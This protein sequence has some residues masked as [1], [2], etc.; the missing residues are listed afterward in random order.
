MYLTQPS[1]FALLASDRSDFWTTDQ[2]HILPQPIWD[3]LFLR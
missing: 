3:A 2:L 1:I